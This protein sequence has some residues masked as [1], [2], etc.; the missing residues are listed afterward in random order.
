MVKKW[1]SILISVLLIVSPLCFSSFLVGATPAIGS[2]TVTLH[3]IADAYVNA[4][5]P[6][7]NYGSSVSLFVS[8]SSKLDY[9]YVMFDLSSLPSEANIIYARLRMYLSDTGGK[10]YGLPSDDV[11]AYYCSDNSWT[12]NGITWNNRPNFNSEPTYTWSFSLGVIF[13]NYRS[14]DVT[15]D[16]KQAFSEE[17][18]TEVVKFESKT[19][20]G[21]VV[22]DSKEN[23]NEPLLEIEYSIEPVHVVNL[24][25]SQD[26][27]VT[28]NLGIITL[29]DESF[30]LPSD[31]D[32]VAGTYQV[33]YS[34]GYLFT[35]WEPVGGVA[36][37]NPLA[38]T[39]TVTVTGD[40]TLK[41]V[42]TANLLEYTYDNGYYGF[43]ACEAKGNIDAV[44]FTPLFSGQLLMARFYMTYISSFQ[45]ETI[46]V[47]IMDENR[48]DVITP[49]EQT[50]DSAGWF[51]VPLSA[52]SIAV[53]VGTDFYIGMEWLTDYSP[54]LG[55]YYEDLSG[56]SWEW[57]GTNWKEVEDN[58]FMIRAVVGE[59]GLIIEPTITDH[60]VVAEGTDFHVVTESNSTI[61]NCQFNKDD[62]QLSFDV[63]RTISSYGFYNVT[64]P[65]ELLGGPFSVTADKQTVSDVLSSGN[66]THTWLHFVYPQAT[67]SVEITGST[68]I[69][70]FPTGT[71]MLLVFVAV[72][73]CVDIYRRKKLK[74]HIG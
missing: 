66:S 33:S 60:I 68:V 10:I 69:P 31:V 5:S 35:H 13:A 50:P 56:R 72:T 4:S 27:G 42:G 39:T 47:H 37:S 3:S 43:T 25:S 73:V 34:G 30:S 70:E 64:I 17:T 9:T 12:E 59:E 15:A 40:G 36:V 57:N 41:A 51:D 55:G 62:K 1:V 16:A 63:S 6:D 52:Y 44:R 65:N 71:V 18:L 20:D 61:S 29:A 19:G 54:T 23:D 14:W 2:T 48:N 11:G 38:A 24:E 67:S 8:A 53:T 49:F 58:D 45:D 7:T 74:R 28:N 21:Y 22:F 46:K 26:T 32:V